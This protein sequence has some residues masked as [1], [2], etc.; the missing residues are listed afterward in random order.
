MSDADTRADSMQPPDALPP[1]P[2][3]VFGGDWDSVMQG[4]EDPDAR[5]RLIALADLVRFWGRKERVLDPL[6][7]AIRDGDPRVRRAAALGL[8]K[9][10]RNRDQRLVD[11]L[12]AAL[13]DE[14]AEA[15]GKIGDARAV[16]PLIDALRDDECRVREKAAEALGAIGDA[17]AV[18]PLI[19]VVQNEPGKN[20]RWWATK[21]LTEID[22]P[23]ATQAVEALLSVLGRV[24]YSDEPPPEPID[25]RRQTIP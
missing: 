17:Q 16:P 10:G 13:C 20:V 19:A 14:D 4:L 15:L 21:A 22:D 1:P 9:T 6:L 5:Y 25:D 2:P 24:M 12:K 8:G 7:K 18:H 3:P 11:A 23:R